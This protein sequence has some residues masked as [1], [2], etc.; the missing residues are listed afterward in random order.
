MSDQRRRRVLAAAGGMAL[1]LALLAMPVA[2]SSAG[3]LQQTAV[4]PTLTPTPD[5][6]GS[7]ATPAPPA[8]A[9]AENP[10]IAGY[11]WV[12]GDPFV[13]AA[14]VP[15]RFTGEGFELATLTDVNGYYQF[16]QVGQDVGFLNVA[17]DGTGWKGSVKDVALSPRPGLSL[18]VN[19]SASQASP[20]KGPKLV[21]VSVQPALIGAG[22]TATVTVKATNTTGYKLSNVWLTHLLPDGLTIAGMITDRGDAVSHAQMAMAN[23]GDLAPGASVTFS[24]VANAPNDGA[25]SGS[26]P[27]V[28]S[29]ISSEGVA[30]QASATLKSTGGP[31]TLPVT[32]S[33]EWLIGVGLGLAGLAVGA[34]QL[35]RRRAAA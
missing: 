3:R 20:V 4:R 15:V 25:P 30:V 19:F 13:P 14:G 23:V 31:A 9:M 2:P 18:R 7:T 34:R 10:S 32:G 28:A 33:G 26:L 24:V 29:M 35:R 17:G 5:A 21:S 16:E 6:P 11:L 1:I 27:I 12:N 22:Q 8:G